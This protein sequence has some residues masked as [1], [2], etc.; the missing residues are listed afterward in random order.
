MQQGL[1]IKGYGGFYFVQAADGVYQCQGR[2]RL[3]RKT[4]SLLPGDRVRI[5]EL[6]ERSGVI[7]SVLPRKNSLQRPPIANV[8]QSVLVCSLASPQPD[9]QLLDRLL[10]LSEAQGLSIL[11]CLTKLDLVEP[12]QAESLAETYRQA[13]YRVVATAA[14]QGKGIDSLAGCLA[15]QVSVLSGPSGVGK[16]TL[17]NALL[18]G[19]ELET[20]EISH[21][22]RRG[23]HTTR[24]VQLLPVAGG[25]LADTPGFSSLELPQIKRQELAGYFPEI[26]QRA[27]DC[28]FIDCLHNHEPD[29]AVKA[30]LERGEVNSQRY[31]HYL[32][33]LNE[34]MAR[35][36]VW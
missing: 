25:Y 35:E 13:G 9:L 32:D 12:E 15:D 26:G 27:G 17:M 21:K 6:A 10:V 3:H 30:A 22:L 14:K 34:V 36:R 23:R 2:G 24:Y 4:G 20:G 8:D 1:V 16:S 11:I 5:T 31:R 33:F 7:E 29:C 28:R 18:P 19:A